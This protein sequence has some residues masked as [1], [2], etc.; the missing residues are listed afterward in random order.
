MEF[1]AARETVDASK[2]LADP[3]LQAGRAIFAQ[4]CTTCHRK[5]QPA[6]PLALTSTVNGPDPR[7][8]MRIIRY[9]IRPPVGAREH[10]MPPFA[11]ITEKDMVNLM[12][13]VRSQFSRNP[14]WP[15]LEHAAR[16]VYGEAKR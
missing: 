13:F 16:E 12:A 3:A 6:A 1:A 10:A 5:G 7:N 2:P 8:A 14:A 9:G 11:W 4:S 15:D